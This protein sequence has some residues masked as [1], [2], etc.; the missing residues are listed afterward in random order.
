MWRMRESRWEEGK[1]RKEGWKKGRVGI[2][3]REKARERVLS[4]MKPVFSVKSKQGGW[5]SHWG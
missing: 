1:G 2:L 4:R 3:H 5:S